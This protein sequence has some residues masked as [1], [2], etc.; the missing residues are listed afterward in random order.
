MAAYWIGVNNL[1]RGLIHTK[2]AV[3]VHSAEEDMAGVVMRKQVT[4]LES[5]LENRKKELERIDAEIL[6]EKKPK[7]KSQLIN[8]SQEKMDKLNETFGNQAKR[9]LKENHALLR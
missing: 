6:A 9:I 5:I 1:E 2:K 3:V 4:D 7:K 8:Q